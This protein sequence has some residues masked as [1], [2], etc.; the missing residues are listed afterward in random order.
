MSGGGPETGLFAIRR[1]DPRLPLNVAGQRES[2]AP[3]IQDK[4]KAIVVD[5]L[6]KMNPGCKGVE[7]IGSIN[8]RRLNNGGQV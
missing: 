4:V 2:K 5:V 3:G 7:S 1:T 8:R 6:I